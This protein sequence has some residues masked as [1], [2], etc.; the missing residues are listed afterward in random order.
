MKKV[1]A[2][3]GR[4]RDGLLHDGMLIASRV[5]SPELPIWPSSRHERPMT[6][7]A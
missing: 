7:P 3:A 2:S 4:A 5:G 6:P 1:N